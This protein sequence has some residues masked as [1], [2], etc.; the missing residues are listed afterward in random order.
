M[1]PVISLRPWR[2]LYTYWIAFK[3]TKITITLKHSTCS[4]WSTQNHSDLTQASI[5]QSLSGSSGVVLH[6]TPDSPAFTLAQNTNGM[7]L[8]QKQCLFH[9]TTTM[10][11]WEI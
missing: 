3:L 7:L 5:L 9:I 2:L 8:M 11:S 1:C 10:K 4:V 6:P